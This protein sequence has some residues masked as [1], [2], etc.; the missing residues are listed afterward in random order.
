MSLLEC[1]LP[2]HPHFHLMRGMAWDWTLV[3]VPLGVFISKSLA[4]QRSYFSGWTHL[5]LWVVPLDS[6]FPGGSAGKESACNAGDLGS[7]PG[8]GRSPGGGKGNPLQYS[9]LE[10][11][12]DDIVPGV[13]KSWTQLS[14]FHFHLDSGTVA[15][16]CWNQGW[17]GVYAFYGGCFS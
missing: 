4:R 2:A 15:A 5:M 6:G 17:D 1:D 8:L 13:A 11:S 12:M 3:A 14:D 7:V 10:S 16:D 9:G